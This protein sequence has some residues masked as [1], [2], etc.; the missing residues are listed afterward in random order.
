MIYIMCVVI[1]LNIVSSFGNL[2][3]KS[4]YKHKTNNFNLFL[5]NKIK[6]IIECKNNDFIDLKL[7]DKIP[8][9]QYAEYNYDVPAYTII[10]HQHKK[11]IDLIEEIKL[12]KINYV[13]IDAGHF[14]HNEIIKLCDFYYLKTGKIIKNDPLYLYKD[15]LVFLEDTDF[16]G[17]IFEMYEIIFRNCL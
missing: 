15:A 6:E 16:I 1:F 8:S 5:K 14:T 9:L 10:A 4:I 12:N 17:G 3:H 13:Y 2:M 7:P 11:V